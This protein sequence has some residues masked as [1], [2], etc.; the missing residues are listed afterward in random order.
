MFTV[1]CEQ[2]SGNGATPAKFL[3]LLNRA[4]FY[5]LK[6]R[7]DQDKFMTMVVARIHN[8]G[9]MVFAGAHNV[10]AL[11]D[12]DQAGVHDAGEQDDNRVDND[13][14][15]ELDHAEVPYQQRG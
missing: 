14:V 11:G 9:R 6:A 13:V 4:M 7:L 1:L 12:A 10:L 2:S 15:A 8:D 3:A 5:N